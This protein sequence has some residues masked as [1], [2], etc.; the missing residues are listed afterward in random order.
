MADQDHDAL[1]ERIPDEWVEA[2]SARYSMH[3]AGLVRNILAGA[4]P[5]IAADVAA[6]V[7]SPPPVPPGVRERLKTAEAKLKEIEEFCWDIARNVP[8]GELGRVPVGTILAM[9]SGWGDDGDV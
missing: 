7:L 1:A 2:A 4:I 3:G 6:A 9:V 8:E 5:L